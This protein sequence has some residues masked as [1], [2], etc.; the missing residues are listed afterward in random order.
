MGF[1]VCL[2]ARSGEIPPFGWFLRTQTG[3]D[4]T[5]ADPTSGKR[6][7]DSDIEMGASERQAPSPA[8]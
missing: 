7:K 6:A 5:M 4:L 3:R 2:V 1:R 8:P